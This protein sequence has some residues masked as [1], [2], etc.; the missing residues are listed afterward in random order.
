MYYLHGGYLHQQGE[1]IPELFPA[2]LDSESSSF[3]ADLAHT[4]VII[5]TLSVFLYGKTWDKDTCYILLRLVQPNGGLFN[6]LDDLAPRNKAQNYWNS[7]AAY[8]ASAT[9]KNASLH[10]LP[11]FC[12]LSSRAFMTYLNFFLRASAFLLSSSW[13]FL[14][15]AI[16]CL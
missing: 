11:I 10:S 14:A 4:I 3:Q 6:C 12:L 2:N 7:P 8:L 5:V 16:F 13:P 9:K 1:D 15:A